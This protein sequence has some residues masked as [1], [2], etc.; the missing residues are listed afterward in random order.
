M[1]LETLEAQL[2]TETKFSPY[3]VKD[4]GL[5]KEEVFEATNKTQ[6]QGYST[7][8]RYGGPS[9]VVVGTLFDFERFLKEL[10]TLDYIEFVGHRKLMSGACPRD[11]IRVAIRHDIDG[12]IVSAVAQAEIE[13]EL[14]IVATWCVLHTAPYYGSFQGNIFHRNE[15]MAPVYRRIQALGHEIALHTDALM[16]YQSHG[17]DG[18]Q[19]LRT[20]LSWLRDQGLHIYGTVAHNSV[21]ANGAWNYEIFNGRYADPGHYIPAPLDS[22]PPLDFAKLEASDSRRPPKLSKDETDPPDWVEFNGQ[23]TPLRILDERELGLEYEAN[24]IF[25]QQGTPVAYGCTMV[26]NGW[27]WNSHVQRLKLNPTLIETQLIDQHRLVEDISRLQRGCCLV[28]V[29]HP[30]FYG[31]RV[32]DKESSPKRLN[33]VETIRSPELG[34]FVYDPEV[35]QCWSGPTD[36]EQEFQAMSKPNAM[37]MLDLPWPEA[38]PKEEELSLLFLGADNID[39]LPVSIPNQIHS[40]V[41]E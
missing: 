2:P 6:Y 20:E 17:I 14:G 5:S 3:V 39:G 15:S 36:R 33:R 30:C 21:T 29:V 26:A 34:W 1:N 8:Y 24:E 18:A 22:D 7:D 27:S 23:R 41:A 40:R 37:G 12:D 31:H 4:S 19:G 11:Q 10:S 38:R 32:N 28:L 35:M 13:K 9:K 25:W 16:I